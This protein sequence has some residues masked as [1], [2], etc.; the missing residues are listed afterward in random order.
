[1]HGRQVNI[2]DSEFQELAQLKAILAAVDSG[3]LLVDNARRTL[4]ANQKYGELFGIPAVETLVISRASPGERRDSIRHTF[5]DPEVVVED[6]TVICHNRSFAGSTGE[7]VLLAPARRVLQPFTTPVIDESGSPVG[8]IWVYHDITRVKMAEGQFWQAQKME[9]IERL[10]GGIAHDFNNLLT[11]IKGFAQLAMLEAPSSGHLKDHI[12]E[13]QWAV[14]RATTLTGQLLVFS[15]RQ[16]IEP[17]VIDLNDSIINLTNLLRRLVGP[18]IELTTLLGPEIISVKADPAQLEQVLVNLVANG[19][20]AMPSGG[21]LTLETS[22]SYLDRQIDDL[23]EG[24]YVVIAVTDTGGG[25][26]EEVKAHLFEPFFTTKGIGK[27][28]GLGLATC[29]GIVKH[30]GGNISVRSEL[31]KGTR[32]EVYLPGSAEFDQGHPGG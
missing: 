3:I 6:W 31:G 16:V 12:Q 21:K 28:A 5:T 1:V 2:P 24:R 10:A 29:Y 8:R 14:E 22:M 30:S 25:M 23:S 17:R 20:D 18:D 11:A 15:R 7:V 13:I 26:S 32:V 27:G 4:W 9:G 19:R